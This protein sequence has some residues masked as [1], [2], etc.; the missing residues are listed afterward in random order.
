MNKINLRPALASM[1]HDQDILYAVVAA[2][3]EEVPSLMNELDQA[4][5][6]N[7]KAT[8]ERASHTL[9]GNFRILQLQNQQTVWANIEQLAHND[10]LPQIPALVPEAKTVTQNVLEQ[11]KSALDS[12]QL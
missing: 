5:A 12:R 8:A 1:D 3:I 9:K 2:F 10:Q 6:A 7:D 11:L 4:L